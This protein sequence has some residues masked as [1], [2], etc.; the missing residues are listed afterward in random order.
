MSCLG[1]S[2]DA[3]GL[4]QLQIPADANGPAIT[5]LVWT[6]CTQPAKAI[7]IDPPFVVPGVRNCP[8]AG[9]GLPLII[10][11]HGLSGG[12]LSHHDT[13]EVL[14]DNGFIVV[15]LTHPLDSGDSPKRAMDPQSMIERPTDVKR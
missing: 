4:A 3:A 8:V 13:A 7:A 15:A 2:A 5:A 6:P 14:G 11:S 10:I 12:A 1:S 9:T